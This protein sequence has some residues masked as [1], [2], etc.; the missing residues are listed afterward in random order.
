MKII[1]VE[2]VPF[3][4]QLTEPFRIA[5]ETITSTMGVLVKIYTDENIVGIG[6]GVPTAMIT[7]ETQ[8]GALHTVNKYLTPILVGKDPFEIGKLVAQMDRVIVGNSSAKA[9][10][11]IALHDILGKAINKPLYN[12]LGGYVH[13]ISTDCTI[14]IKK[15]E[16]MAKDALVIV[17]RGFNTIKV[18]IGVDVAEDVE[19][20]RRIREA[21][22]DDIIIRVDANQGYSAKTAIRVIH[23]LEPYRIQL[24]E[25]P[26]PAWNIEGLAMVKHV[27]SVPIMADESIHSPQDAVEIIKRDAADMINIKLMKAGG[28]FKA[29]QIATVA[30]A[31]GIPCMVGCMEET[32]VSITAAAQLAV[33]TENVR[34]ADLDSPLFLREDPVEEGGVEYERDMLK[35]PSLPGIGV[36]LKKV[37]SINSL[38]KHKK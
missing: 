6:E 8:E 2:A 13:D 25:Q 12:L 36:V 3:D 22:G 31:A 29:R 7:G 26:V 10:V 20:V 17:E 34:E 23:K 5:F 30:E 24:V 33:S 38:H 16:E 21:V 28:I 37:G 35:M 4:I 1:K 14:G 27:V 32:R 15:P 11:D 9:A 19:R 18:K